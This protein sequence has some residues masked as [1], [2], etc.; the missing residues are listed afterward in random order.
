MKIIHV[1]DEL[2][3]KAGGLGRGPVNQAAAQAALGHAVILIGRT[4]GNLLLA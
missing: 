3:P 4:G 1:A 2:Q